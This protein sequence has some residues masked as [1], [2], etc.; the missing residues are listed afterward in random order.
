M[1]TAI[2]LYSGDSFLKITIEL[3]DWRGVREGGLIPVAI[4]RPANC[5][6]RQFGVVNQPFSR[7][8][9]WRNGAKLTTAPR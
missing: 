9:V 2:N 4:T 5:M 1:G 6:S 3:A 8:K 7:E